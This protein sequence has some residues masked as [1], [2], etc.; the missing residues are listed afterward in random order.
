MKETNIVSTSSFSKPEQQLLMKQKLH[1]ALTVLI[2]IIELLLLLLYS[3]QCSDFTY[4]SSL[5]LSI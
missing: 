4:L 5:L 1:S 2:Q 3:I